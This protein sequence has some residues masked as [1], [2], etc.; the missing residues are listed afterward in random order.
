MNYKSILVLLLYLLVGEIPPFDSLDKA[1]TQNLYI[2]IVNILCAA[3]I[4]Y[5]RKKHPFRLKTKPI[6]VFLFLFFLW[7][8]ITQHKQ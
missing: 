5:D 1:I 4:I 3:L 2:Y 8:I 7:S 6:F